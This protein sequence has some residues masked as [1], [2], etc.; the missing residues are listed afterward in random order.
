MEA[1][2][3][4][5]H[6]N[7]FVAV[8]FLFLSGCGS[9]PAPTASA[10]EA[11]A[12]APESKAA[13]AAGSGDA[14]SADCKVLADE[15][16]HLMAVATKAKGFENIV[17]AM[18]QGEGTLRAKT[19]RDPNVGAIA[20]DY[21]DMLRDFSGA[22]DGMARAA[23]AAG[24]QLEKGKSGARAAEPPPPPPPEPDWTRESV[25]FDRMK[26]VCNYNP[27]PGMRLGQ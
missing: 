22:L 20:V 24:E 3:L 2:L 17:S 12:S 4:R 8:S 23:L 25:L 15:V 13:L 21:A 9:S 1:R 10:P 11:Q 18:R 7:V 16:D 19:W 14:R 6:N 27:P 26:T 5:T